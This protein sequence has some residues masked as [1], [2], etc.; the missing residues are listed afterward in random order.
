[1]KKNILTAIAALL[2]SLILFTTVSYKNSIVAAEEYT[3]TET[4]EAT[5][6]ETNIPSDIVITK[7]VGG[8]VFTAGTV[9]LKDVSKPAVAI[10]PTQPVAGKPIVKPSIET[11]TRIDKEETTTKIVEETTTQLNTETSEE[12]T[13]EIVETT[14]K[15][16]WAEKE[17]EYPVAT[18]IWRYMKDLGWSDAVCAGIMGN[19]MAEVGG[20][21]LNI[22][23]YLY[24]GGGSYYGIC[25]WYLPYT[26]RN[27]AGTG[28]ETQCN[29]LR[30]TIKKEMNMFGYKYSSSMNYS[31]FLALSSPSEA[32]LAFAKC[33]ERCSSSYYTVRQTNAQKAY[34]YFVG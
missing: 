16:M 18:Y 1:M 20:H 10:K 23:P 4:I 3:K 30:D 21:T 25:Q 8:K 2:M 29:Y 34:N 6:S 11:T 27:I 7:V 15:D 12:T 31:N 13:T 24:G 5:I 22:K 33:Y 32:A 26:T 28:V 9:E 19:M 17:A 14:T